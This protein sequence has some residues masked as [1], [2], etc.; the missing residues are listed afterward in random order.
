[1]DPWYGKECP[2]FKCQVSDLDPK[3]LPKSR[4]GDKGWCDMLEILED[5]A[6]V[7]QVLLHSGE[8]GFGHKSKRTSLINCYHRVK[9][10]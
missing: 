2:L 8:R 10:D 1:M 4:G 3:I 7:V 6:V 9:N 5:D